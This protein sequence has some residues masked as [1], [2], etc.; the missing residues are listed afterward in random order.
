MFKD[1]I[2]LATFNQIFAFA[3]NKVGVENLQTHPTN[4]SRDIAKISNWLL[5]TRN[6]YFAI[7]NAPSSFPGT[8][9]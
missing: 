3:R 7:C 1:L 5:I 2:F 8:A 4:S 6:D 9:V